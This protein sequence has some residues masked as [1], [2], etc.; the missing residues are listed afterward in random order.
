MP[1]MDSH[2]Y[3]KKNIF[4]DYDSSDRVSTDTVSTEFST[5]QGRNELLRGTVESLKY[6]FDL[7]NR[8]TEQSIE[9]HLDI[10][11]NNTNQE[12]LKSK[13][14]LRNSEK[15]LK[16]S[17]LILTKNVKIMREIM[18]KHREKTKQL[19]E[20]VVYQSTHEH[21]EYQDEGNYHELKGN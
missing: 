20:E 11:G 2:R 8:S 16:Q 1:K 7:L 14:E 5:L 21:D 3:G 17:T 19:L 9:N 18:Q 12:K 6:A 13:S 15:T 4:K 10:L